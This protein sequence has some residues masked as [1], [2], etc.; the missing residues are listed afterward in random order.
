MK[1]VELRRILTLLIP[2]LAGLAMGAPQASAQLATCA[3]VDDFYAPSDLIYNYN[4]CNSE[5]P[6]AA[7]VRSQTDIV[8][9]QQGQQIARA[10]QGS[11]SPGLLAIFPSGRW[12]QSHHDGLELEGA[13][14]TTGEIDSNEFSAFLNASYDVPGVV[15]GGQLK[16]NGIVG[17]LHLKA[18]QDARGGFFATKSDNDSFFIGVGNVWSQ[19]SFYTSSTFIYFTGETEARFTDGAGGTGGLNRIPTATSPT[20]LSAT[21]STCPASWII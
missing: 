2:A 19:G 12:M 5:G 15:F 3:A 11:H 9:D 14:F 1:I 7:Q 10:L 16:I 13:N 8:N 6:T 4:Y 18:E 21:C 20:A 17:G